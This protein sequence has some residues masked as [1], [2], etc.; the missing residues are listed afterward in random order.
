[1]PSKANTFRKKLKRPIPFFRFV[2]YTGGYISAAFF[3]VFFPTF[4]RTSFRPYI[5]PYFLTTYRPYYKMIWSTAEFEVNENSWG[6]LYMDGPEYKIEQQKLKKTDKPKGREMYPG[7]FL[8]PTES[9]KDECLADFTVPTITCFGD[10]EEH[11]PVVLEDASCGIGLKRVHL[12]FDGEKVEQW[13]SYRPESMDEHENYLSWCEIRLVETLRQHWRLFE[14][15]NAT[16]G[17]DLSMEHPTPDEG[18]LTMTI[19]LK[20]TLTPLQV[21]MRGPFVWDQEGATLLVKLHNRKIEAS[22]GFRQERFRTAGENAAFADYLD[23]VCHDIIDRLFEVG[24]CEVFLGR[25]SKYLFEVDV[26]AIDDAPATKAAAPK[27]SVA[28]APA[29]ARPTTPTAAPATVVAAVVAKPPATVA[30][31]V[32]AKAPGPKTLDTLRSFS[33][34]VRWDKDGYFHAIEVLRIHQRDAGKIHD[35]L[36]AALRLCDDCDISRANNPKYLFV[37]QVLAPRR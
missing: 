4:F 28:P 1:V 29:V 5:L 23:T 14:V 8:M 34:Y 19:T 35:D 30:A 32:V 6:S 17:G 27:A 12:R 31:A 13:Q 25:N 15:S 20:E 33:R 11:F 9:Q 10:L 3:R 24:G 18:A 2:G 37:V 7:V 36:L 22:G 21:L 16:G 26:F